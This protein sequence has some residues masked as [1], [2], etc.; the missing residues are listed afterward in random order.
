MTLLNEI[1]ITLETFNY[2][3]VP[4]KFDYSKVP[5]EI[6]YWNR[7]ITVKIDPASGFSVVDL[8]GPDKEILKSR[9][10]NPRSIQEYCKLFDW[11]LRNPGK[12][13]A[14]TFEDWRSFLD[15]NRYNYWVGQDSE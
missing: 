5:D 9:G 12:F 4:D 15:K 7:Q 14:M 6:E 3:N 2:S 10:S 1:R 11:A 8:V 13:H